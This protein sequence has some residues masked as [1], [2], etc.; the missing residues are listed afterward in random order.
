MNIW[1]IIAVILLILIGILGYMLYVDYNQKLE[2][3]KFVDFE[4]EETTFN[5][6]SENLTESSELLLC[7]IPEDK[8]VVLT[9][10]G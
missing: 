7:N 4:I 5:Q 3:Y 10:R 6:L 9:K 1:K 2:T 8:C